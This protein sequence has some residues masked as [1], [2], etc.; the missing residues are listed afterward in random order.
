MIKKALIF[1]AG[2][3]VGAGIAWKITSDKYNNLIDEEVESV[4]QMYAKRQKEDEIDES[5][6]IHQFKQERSEA[7]DIC[8]REGYTSSIPSNSQIVK[9]GL[10]VYEIW[11]DQFGEFDDYET[12]SLNYYDDHV[13]TDELDH[14]FEDAEEALGDVLDGYFG[15]YDEDA[16][17]IR[18]EDR[19]TDYEVLRVLGEYSIVAKEGE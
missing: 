2:V 17:Y 11:P 19:M 4:K 6:D 9:H 5:F 3:A 14:V 7:D 10:T 15:E 1:A 12:V 13:I 8:E 16:I 18:N